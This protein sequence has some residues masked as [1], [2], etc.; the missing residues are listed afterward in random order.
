MAQIKL[1]KISSDGTPLEMSTSADE[2]TLLSYTVTGGG[3]VLSGTGLD[4]NGQDVSDIS[5]LVFTDPSVGTI[6]QT[7][8]NLIANNI[9]AKE[10]SNTMTTAADILFP[11]VTDTAGELDA[12]RLPAIAGTPTATPTAAGEGF[13]VWDSTNDKMY[14]W[15]GSAWVDQTTVNSVANLEDSYTADGAIAAR[16]VVYISGSGTVK[17]AQADAPATSYAI[18]FAT[19]TVADTNPVTVRKNGK[20]S[21]FT[22]LTPGARQ[23][24]SAATAGLITE[25]LPTGTGNTIV[26]LGYALTSA[27][28]DIQ[29]AGL[30]RRA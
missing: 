19:A 24:L 13:A 20:L 17:K 28:V 4:M 14:I 6:N 18:G 21:G 26:Q 12:F 30:G 8:G 10:R 15:N 22:G 16:D 1:L 9:M 2:V 3:P 5:D 11:V 23:Y 25:T 27:I 7:A 29:V